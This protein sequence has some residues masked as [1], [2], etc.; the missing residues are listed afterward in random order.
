MIWHKVRSKTHVDIQK[1]TWSLIS[2]ESDKKVDFSP[3][4][5]QIKVQICL[6]QS[7]LLCPCWPVSQW[8]NFTSHNERAALVAGGLGRTR[9]RVRVFRQNN[10]N[11]HLLAANGWLLVRGQ[12]LIY[13]DKQGYGYGP[14]DRWIE[15]R[16]TG[17]DRV[18]L[19]LDVRDVQSILQSKDHHSKLQ[20]KGVAGKN[21]SDQ[22]TR[23]SLSLTRTLLFNFKVLF[24][25]TLHLMHFLISL[26]AVV[27]HVKTNEQARII[28]CTCRP[29][30]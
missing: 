24:S 22:W 12:Q 7:A 9:I 23:T 6:T 26:C 19:S 5:K 20:V 21:R 28:V 16:W 15:S 4:Q 30:T 3:G 10:R 25:F 27:W 11:H 14:R 17:K 18:T 13:G 8:L 29:F 2:P 1:C